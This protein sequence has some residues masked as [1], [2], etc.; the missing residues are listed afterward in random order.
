MKTKLIVIALC[1]ILFACKKKD[2]TPQKDNFSFSAFGQS[3]TG[4][5]NL[6]G[7][8][9]FD[10]TNKK[11]IL[12]DAVP[13]PE[14][15]YHTG[16]GHAYYNRL[17]DVAD[18]FETSF[19]FTIS[20]LGGI[21]DVDGNVGGDGLAFAIFNS[22]TTKIKDN[23]W[24]IGMENSIA[25]E[26]DTYNNGDDGG[27]V[28]NHDDP[29]GN[30]IA[31]YYCTASTSNVSTRMAINASVADFSSAGTHTVK[32]IYQNKKINVYLDGAL[33]LEANIDLSSVLTL[34]SGKAYIDLIGYSGASGETHK[35]NNWSF[36]SY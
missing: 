30:H 5:I 2:T 23:T 10:K 4:K 34:N 16:T 28:A 21:P 36:K 33:S 8:A 3:D 20:D 27:G 29:N 6:T 12:N 31:M 35:I 1:S 15:S 14:H 18:G 17:V 26:F 25:I 19:N 13:T 24:Y 11:L 32:I 22:D 9:Y 7:E